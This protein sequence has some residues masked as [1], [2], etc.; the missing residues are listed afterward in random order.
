MLAIMRGPKYKHDGED[1]GEEYSGF[2]PAKALDRGAVNEQSIARIQLT[3]QSINCMQRLANQTTKALSGDLQHAARDAKFALLAG[4]WNTEEWGS[5]D[6][7][8][9]W[10][11]DPNVPI[12]NAAKSVF[13]GSRSDCPN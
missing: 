11:K 5:I 1:H 13:E 8:E 10:L 2:S 12:P 7:F 9:R 4:A 3:V 6:T